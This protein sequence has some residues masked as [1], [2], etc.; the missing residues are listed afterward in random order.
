MRWESAQYLSLGLALFSIAMSIQS[1]VSTRMV[2]EEILAWMP[3]NLMLDVG[4]MLQMAVL[5]IERHNSGV[6][7]LCRAMRNFTSEV[8]QTVVT[9]GGPA[10]NQ[11]GVQLR[12]ILNTA[13]YSYAF[14]RY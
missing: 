10:E 6:R 8:W 11:A 7:T 3:L 12:G 1:Y 13:G 5:I 2:P 9:C 4:A 14:N